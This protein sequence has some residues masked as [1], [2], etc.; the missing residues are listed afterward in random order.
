M[1]LVVLY[2]IL[3]V[4]LLLLLLQPSSAETIEVCEKCDFSTIQDA[5]NASKEG[6]TILVASGMY[7]EN[8]KI[9]K[10]IKIV[11]SDG[12]I[13]EPRF[14]VFPT[15]Q[16]ALVQNFVIEN[17]QI[18]NGS[19]GLDALLL[20]GFEIENCIFQNNFDAISI[21]QS[22]QGKL[23]GLSVRGFSVGLKV[24][25]SRLVKVEDGLFE[26]G[27]TGL[28]IEASN[29]IALSNLSINGVQRG[30]EFSGGEGNLVENSVFSGDG[31]DVSDV[32]IS[33]FSEN[34]LIVS[35]ND[36]K[37]ILAVD[38]A[39]HGNRYAFEGLNVSG[40]EFQISLEEVELSERFVKLSDA[41]NATITPDIYSGAGYVYVEFYRLNGSSMERVSDYYNSSD[42]LPLNFVSNESGIYFLGAEIIQPEKTP[43]P[44]APAKTPTP[45]STPAERKWIPGFEFLSVIVG[46]SVA[47]ILRERRGA[48]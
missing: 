42:F 31:S 22:S 38:E 13:L 35:G 24:E 7:R 21:S 9:S 3:A 6:D 45:V 19:V 14:I 44:S 23:G 43:T 39:S 33:A 20:N 1:R 11:G 18:K 25:G 12:T 27:V 2:S 5:I 37:G 28:N 36:V 40:R 29:G 46:I 17:V 26:D 48:K 16:V 32:F 34:G 47:L 30:I 8:L 41:V 10:S 15:I 4:I